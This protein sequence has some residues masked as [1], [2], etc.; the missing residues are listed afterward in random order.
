MDTVLWIMDFTSRFFQIALCVVFLLGLLM[1]F[2]L[3]LSTKCCIWLPL[4]RHRNRKSLWPRRLQRLTAKNPCPSDAN[5]AV[6]QAASGV[7]AMSSA[8]PPSPPSSP[9]VQCDDTQ[10][11]T[12]RVCHANRQ[13]TDL[14]T[15]LKRHNKEATKKP[16][17]SKRLLSF[18]CRKQS[19]GVKTPGAAANNCCQ[20]KG[21]TEGSQV[22][23]LSTARPPL[24][25]RP[26]RPPPPRRIPPRRTATTT[27][28]S[29]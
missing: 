10:K 25:P 24:P 19:S 15:L 11:P 29:P 13:C 5:A 6:A 28:N 2:L 26:P 12:T 20:Q 14:A 1:A 9:A 21:G 7:S 8:S 16:S 18:R 23:A 17:L 3:F 22:L 27:S 4:R